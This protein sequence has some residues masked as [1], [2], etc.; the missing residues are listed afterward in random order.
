MNSSMA[1]VH[2]GYLLVPSDDNRTLKIVPLNHPRLHDSSD[3]GAW[4][5]TLTHITYSVEYL[6]AV[7][8]PIG[9]DMDSAAS[10]PLQCPPQN[11]HSRRILLGPILTSNPAHTIEIGRNTMCLGF[12]VLALFNGAPR[13][14]IIRH[15]LRLP[16]VV[17]AVGEGFHLSL[18]VKHIFSFEG[19]LR[20][21][22][23]S[24][25]TKH[26]DRPGAALALRWIPDP[27]MEGNRFVPCV[28]SYSESWD[29]G[30]ALG[31]E[32]RGAGST[33]ELV[34]LDTVKGR[35]V[36]VPVDVRLM[37]SVMSEWSK[38]SA[39]DVSGMLVGGVDG[40]IDIVS[41]LE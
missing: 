20:T 21:K 41:L 29:E 30:G 35:V 38:W 23:S 19:W 4:S 39:C 3:R 31:L 22:Q 16:A 11:E 28:Y 9:I 1:R 32:D 33:P 27:P 6:G 37:D 13:T 10:V 18:R 26:T 2:A 14:K 36:D 7:E 34:P 5:S 8:P 15:E 25:S 17:P 40:D 12:D 24:L